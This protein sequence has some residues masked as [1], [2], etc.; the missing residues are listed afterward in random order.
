MSRIGRQNDGR[1]L[2]LAEWPRCAGR[3]CAVIPRPF[4][5]DVPKAELDDLNR[6]LEST[7]WLELSAGAGLLLRGSPY[8]RMSDCFV[9]TNSG[10]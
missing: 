10:R 1:V 3:C 2:R 4:A 5:I 8:A 9:V 7:R 6:H